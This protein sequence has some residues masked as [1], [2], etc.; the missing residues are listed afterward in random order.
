MA[1]TT[2]QKELIA[3]AAL[4]VIAGSI[5]YFHVGRSTTASSGLSAKQLFAD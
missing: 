5:W 4:V 1:Q 2:Q 3:L